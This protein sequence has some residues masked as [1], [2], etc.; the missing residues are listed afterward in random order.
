MQNVY[1]LEA[2]RSIFDKGGFS[3]PLD[4]YGKPI[5][6]T[7]KKMLKS[8]I[9]KNKK[10]DRITICYFIITLKPNLDAKTTTT[11]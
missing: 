1:Y 8:F 11:P 6:A 10:H 2:S 9:K 3:I 5:Y 7:N 4:E